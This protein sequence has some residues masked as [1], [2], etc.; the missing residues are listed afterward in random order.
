[1]AALGWPL[2]LGLVALGLLLAVIGYVAVWYG[3]SWVL[4][5]A[6]RRRQRQRAQARMAPLKP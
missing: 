3:W 1:M 2:A 6:W 5:R 4:L